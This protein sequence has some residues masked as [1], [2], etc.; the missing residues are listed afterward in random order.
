MRRLSLV[1]GLALLM[2]PAAATIP[3]QNRPQAAAA[4]GFQLTVDSIMR[5]PDLVGWPPTALRWSAD[6][7]NLYFDWRQPGEDESH[8]YVVGRDG[9]QPRRLSDAEEKAAPPANGRWDQAHERVLSVDGG[10]IVLVDQSGARRQITRTT[11][12]ES[13]PRWARHD[14]HITYVRDGNLFIVP[15]DGGSGALIAQLTDVGPKRPEPRL[16]DSQKFLRGE[17]E[18]LIGYVREQQEDKKKAEAREQKDKLPALE[19][20]DRQSAVDLML[21]PDD[22]H[23]FVVVSERPV[24]AR[25]AI[26]PRWVNETAYIEDIPARSY[27]G[28]TQARRMLAILNLKTGKTVWA[29]GSFAPPAADDKA[30]EPAPAGAAGRPARKAER[31]IR[32]S[33]P[34]V[35]DDAKYVVASARS[36]DNKDRWF[37]TLD[38]DTGKTNVI[39]T[40]HDDAWIREL[41]FGGSGVEFLP[42]NKRVWFLSER[43]G[44][45]HLYTLDLSSDVPAAKQLT[46]GKWEITSAELARD[47]RKF[48]ITSTE[49]HPGERHLYSLPIDGG[50]RT[51]IT[52]MTGSNEAEVSPDDSMLGIV[53]LV[54]QQAARGVP[55]AECARRAG[56]ADHDDADRGVA[57]VQLDRS[58]GHHL[59]GAGRRGRPC[60]AVH[61]RDDRRAP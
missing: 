53:Y 41:G 48:Y 49:V 16:T 12:S 42:D 5:G 10:D 23:V 18:S 55:G 46:S 50:A 21:S 40:L 38:P 39:D 31:E 61:A 27:V 9:G 52:S 59:Q 28:D 57:V 34:A 32:W 26:V 35:S 43:D 17:E 8:T 54:Q 45:M 47:G 3:A 60:A 7:R 44:W 30:P 36:A 19:L 51:R 6:S 58:E 1:F 56:P 13:N 24:G 22:I 11:G 2:G 33:M 4:G 20:Q 29:D 37:V 15:V 25:N 14:T